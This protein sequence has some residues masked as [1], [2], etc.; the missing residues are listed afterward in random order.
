MVAAFNK[1]AIGWQ[2]VF[3]N[4]LTLRADTVVSAWKGT[5]AEGLLELQVWLL[6]LPDDV[7]KMRANE[8]PASIAARHCRGA[9]SHPHGWILPKLWKLYEVGPPRVAAC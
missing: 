8:L 9:P 3:D 7:P 1:S 5:T 6:C 4:N 2:E